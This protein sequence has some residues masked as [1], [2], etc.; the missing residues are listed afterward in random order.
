M[1]CSQCQQDVPA[2][3]QMAG[4][5]PR[6]VR[7]NHGP[8][9]WNRDAKLDVG[10]SLSE[11]PAVPR[12]RSTSPDT[13]NSLSQQESRERWRRIGRLLHGGGVTTTATSMA[14]LPT[15]WQCLDGLEKQTATLQPN[16]K[17]PIEE[18]RDCDSPDHPRWLIRGMLTLGLIGLLSGVALL[19]WSMAFDLAEMWKWGMTTTVAAECLL[20]SALA[21]MAA[22]LW[23]HSRRIQAEMQN[24]DAQLDEIHELT[25]LLSAGHQSGS[26]HFYHHF[27][28]VA[29]PHM[30]V[31]N[32]RG[33][34]DQ[35][36]ERM[37]G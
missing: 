24:V 18:L 31:A 29:N 33:Q 30:L 4:E 7:C 8:G 19:A 35:L 5:P 15:P 10:I 13:L 9:P 2:I 23:R 25:G 36:A 20:V 16:N 34:I 21:G 37:A 14:T 3:S 32:L 6:C 12:L 26:Q 22:R 28:Q 11:F 1:W 17:L 27:S